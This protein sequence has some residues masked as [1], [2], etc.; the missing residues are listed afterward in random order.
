MIAVCDILTTASARS[1]LYFRIYNKFNVTRFQEWQSYERWDD[2]FVKDDVNNIFNAF[3]NTY[4]KIFNACFIK[5]RV[6]PKPNHN[7][8]ITYGIRTSCKRKREL[9]LKLRQ[10]DDPKL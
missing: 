5:K 6:N 1:P 3:L 7:I 8:W 2:V 4:T 9:Q 10:E